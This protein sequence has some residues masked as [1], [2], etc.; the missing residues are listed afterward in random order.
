MTATEV[1]HTK[2]AA[3]KEEK[4][5]IMDAVSEQDLESNFSVGEF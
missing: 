5:S 4:F 3:K 2:D 1:Q